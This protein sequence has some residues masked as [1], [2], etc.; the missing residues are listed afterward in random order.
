MGKPSEVPPLKKAAIISLGCAKNQ[1]DSELI[2]GRL[3]RDGWTIVDD[4]ERADAVVVNTCSFIEDARRESVDTLLEA[5]EWKKRGQSRK[6]VAA[7]CLVQRHGEEL[8]DSLPDLDAMVGIDDI[9]EAERRIALPQAPATAK[10]P[11]SGSAQTL[12]THHDPRVRLSAPW[13]AFVKIS[14][15]CD[16]SCAF[17]AI[18]SFRGRM[19]S[20]TIEDLCCEITRLADEGVVEANL[21]AQ[22][23]TSYGR[24]IGHHR[25]LADLIEAIEDLDRAPRWVRVHYLYPSRID[26]HLL[27]TFASARRVVPY[28]D[29]PLQHAHED[30]LRRMRRGGS[31]T[32]SLSL[33]ERLRSTREDA[34][35]RSAFIVGFPG[36]SEQ[37]FETLIDFV[38]QARFD[39]TAVFSYSHEDGTHAGRGEDDVPPEVKNERRQRLSD[40]ASEV[41][42]S[43]NRERIGR[44]VEILVENVDLQ[45]GLVEGRWSGQAVE[46]DGCVIIEDTNAADH[47]PG[48]W[49][50]CII[51]DAGPGE[52]FAQ[53]IDDAQDLRAQ[54][55]S[56]V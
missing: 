44:E 3:R 1:V 31:A 36:E 20:R 56:G 2:L 29:I 17:C 8:A 14:E 21:I 37:E 34:A 41:S 33:I 25:G 42:E 28:F 10:P 54:R 12:F 13:T 30:T 45:Q 43:V 6:V 11:S 46:V 5:L 49:M 15:G 24:D 50:R 35:I 47:A 19:R 32:A 52:L 23:T 22:D 7:G 48:S 53:T 18:P 4:P 40:V 9:A 27:Q 51:E 38:R 55:R 16:Q 26:D 39:V